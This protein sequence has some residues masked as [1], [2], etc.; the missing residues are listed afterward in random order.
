ME[1]ELEN[2]T[3]AYGNE[4]DSHTKKVQETRIKKKLK[5]KTP[6]QKREEK[7]S[8]TPKQK[9]ILHALTTPSTHLLDVL[10]KLDPVV[11]WEVRVEALEEV[12]QVLDDN[13]RIVIS[14]EIPVVVRVVVV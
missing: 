3:R 5:E 10:A 1:D 6:R 11:H 2:E 12:T 9:V 14:F 8:E 4:K 13:V 7:S